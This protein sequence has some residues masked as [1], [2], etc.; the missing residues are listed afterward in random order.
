MLA[1]YDPQSHGTVAQGSLQGSRTLSL[2]TVVGNGTRA[3]NNRTAFARRALAT[4]LWN[5]LLSRL[6]SQCRES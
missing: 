3:R 2:A 5:R 6:L 1:F 4:R